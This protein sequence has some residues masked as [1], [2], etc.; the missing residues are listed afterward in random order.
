MMLSRQNNTE[1]DMISRI[2]ERLKAAMARQGLSSSELAKRSEVKPSFIY[3]ILNGKSTN[4][5]TIKLAQ[6]AQTLG[7]SL[8]SLITDDP[9]SPLQQAPDKSEFVAVPAMLLES[10]LGGG[11]VAAME[12]PVEPY[13]FRRTWLKERL[14]VEPENLKMVFVRGDDMEPT[15][16]HN[17]VVL[18]DVSKKSPTPPGLFV[19]YDGMGVVVKRVE[20]ISQSVPPA[21]RIISDNDKYSP[22]ERPAND[23][24][25]LGRVVWFAREL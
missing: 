9:S 15:L 19:L 2:A 10:Y 3:D 11:N 16:H 8:T 5:S 18:V 22:Y 14:R 1:P 12:R 17:D 13:Y 25:I 24:H 6:V 4:P 20:Y 23:T 21:L 7:M